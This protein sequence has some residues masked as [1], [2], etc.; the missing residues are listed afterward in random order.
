LVLW[1]RHTSEL[2]HHLLA[3][4]KYGEITEIQTLLECLAPQKIILFLHFPLAL[5]L[6]WAHLTAREPGK[7][8]T[9]LGSQEEEELDEQF[10]V[11][12]SL[13]LKRKQQIN[14]VFLGK[15]TRKRKIKIKD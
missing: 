11:C 9:E 2:Q 5:S 15:L 4:R 14:K 10:L 6:L 13:Q 1:F 7:D 8:I 3:A 12:C